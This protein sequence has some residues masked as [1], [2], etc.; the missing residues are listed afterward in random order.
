M[1]RVV[2]FEIPA[3]DPARCERF[4]HQVFGWTFHKWS[5]PQEYWL[6]QTG[7]GARGIDGGMAQRRDPGEGTVNTIEVDSLDDAL[8]RVQAS[9]GSV[10]APKVSIQGIGWIAYCTDTESNTFGLL[11]P[12][13]AAR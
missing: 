2:H 8:H 10:A 7:T 5:G 6:V 12:D 11:Q 9:G 13:A 1:A 3:N 4:Y